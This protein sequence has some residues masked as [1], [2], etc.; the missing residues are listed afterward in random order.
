MNNHTKIKEQSENQRDIIKGALVNLSGI[1]AKSINVIF[2]IFLGRF[3]GPAV[4]G[5]YLLSLTTIDIISKLAIL[6]LDRALITE[7]AKNLAADNETGFYRAVSNALKIGFAASVVTFAFIELGAGFTVSFV[8]NKSELELPVRIMGTG[9]F[10]WTFSAVFIA[11]SR[12]IRIM[13]YEVIIKSVSEPLIMLVSAVFLYKYNL[14]ITALSIAFVVSTMAGSVMSVYLFSRKF[15]LKKLQEA[16]LVSKTGLREMFLFSSPTGIY[17]M[18]NLLLQRIDFFVLTRFVSA[19]TTGVYGIAAEIAF[20][21][22]KVRQSF[23]PI[24][25]PVV[26]DLF[27]KK[28]FYEV[29]IH[30]KNVTRWIFTIDF[31]IFIVFIIAGK[32]ISALFGNDFSSGYHAL[33]ILALSVLINGSFGISELFFLIEKPWINLLNTCGTIIVNVILNLFLVPKFAMTGA[34]LSM[35][36][37]YIFMNTAR[38][39]EVSLIYGLSPF[40][41]QLYKTFLAGVILLFIAGISIFLLRGI[42]YIEIALLFLISVLFAALLLFLDASPEIKKFI[43]KLKRKKNEY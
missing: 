25:I 12:S 9:L 43:K 21:V 35:V 39:V 40:S 36:V 18:L 16:I 2:F 11:A 30:F 3:Y 23:D 41:I 19:A 37:S 10:F 27:E 29:N 31:Y 15:S 8:L 32:Y 42:P 1:L 7:G 26:S 14:G 38:T 28:K 5:L 13:K 22:K 34:A 33:L 6:G 17:D 4:T 24:F 20:S